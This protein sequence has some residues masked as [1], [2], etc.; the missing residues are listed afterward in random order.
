MISK[1]FSKNLVAIGSAGFLLIIGIPFVKSKTIARSSVETKSNLTV[2][3]VET[4]EVRQA[5]SYE[6]LR[7]YTGEIVARR[8]SELGFERAGNLV[9]FGVDRGDRVIK[10]T[11]IA[12]LD[13]RNLQ[14]QRARL[15]AQKA[16]AIAVLSELQNGARA[17]EIA[18]AKAEVSN[19]TNQ[20]Q[21]EEI[22]ADRRRSL[23]SQGAIS[24][25]NLDEI[26]YTAKALSDR[27]N[28]A[29][30]RLEELL[31]GTRSEQIEAQ[32]A[33]VRQLDASIAELDVNID[34][35]TIRAPFS[36]IIAARNTDEGTVIQA[37]QSVVRL[38]EDATPE[39]EIGVPNEILSEL[40]I[41]SNR[42]VKVGDRTYRAK[43]VSILPEIDPATQT[44]TIILKLEG[45]RSLIASKEVARLQITRSVNNSGYWLPTT[46]LVRSEKG[47]WSCFVVI[48]IGSNYRIEKRDLEVLHSD[49]D[50]VFVRGTLSE[51]EKVVS[52][53]T[54]RLVPEQLVRPIAGQRSEVRGQGSEVTDNSK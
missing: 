10:G 46:A 38:V 3:P 49:G 22:K 39:V 15:L 24:R 14:A 34:K 7:N 8:A 18:A 27:L 20:L 33:A 50:R 4:L 41:G 23:Y 13:T 28:I 37:G 21:L 40:Q 36:G 43:V 47:L 9:W 35:S 11:A 2:L 5:N 16:Q 44:R 45:N 17:E 32:K 30:S 48:E 31:N 26:T 6:V 1:S 29:R 19:L 42:K 12:K 53:G 51:G 54:Q 25:E 52:Q